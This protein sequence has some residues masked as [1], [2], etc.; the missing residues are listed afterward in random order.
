MYVITRPSAFIG[1]MF[2]RL[3]TFTHRCI[4]CSRLINKL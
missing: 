2:T 4:D 1:V 3:I